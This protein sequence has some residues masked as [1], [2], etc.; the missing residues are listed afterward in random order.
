MKTRSLVLVLALL[1]SFF[2]APAHAAEPAR[3]TLLIGVDGM[4]A[5]MVRQGMDEGFLPTYRDL[6]QNGACVNYDMTSTRASNG[7]YN[8]IS[9]ANWTALF[10]G[11]EFDVHGVVNNAMKDK[12]SFDTSFVNFRYTPTIAADLAKAGLKSSMFVEWIPLAQVFGRDF[13]TIYPEKLDITDAVAKATEY[14]KTSDDAFTFVHI[15]IV[16]HAGHTKGFDPAL[17]EYKDSGIDSDKMIAG[18][19][20]ALRSR[21]AIAQEQ[22]LVI[23]TTDHGGYETNHNQFDNPKVYNTFMVT[24]ELDK[25]SWRKVDK[26]VYGKAAT[27]AVIPGMIERFLLNR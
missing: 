16:D 13:A 21:A 24:A 5:E 9:G 23:I 19:L 25:G 26:D 8:T 18:M 11:V 10:T 22:W 15:D 2:I 27:I 20:Q 14:L 4:L 6:A 1:C 3:K 12:A 7:K 17:K